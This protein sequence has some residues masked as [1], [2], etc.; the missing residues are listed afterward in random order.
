MHSAAHNAVKECS[1]LYGQYSTACRTFSRASKG[2]RAAGVSGLQKD[3]AC[4]PD[5]RMSVQASLPIHPA[6]GRGFHSKLACAIVGTPLRMKAGCYALARS[7]NR[8][9]YSQSGL[10]PSLF[11]PACPPDIRASV[12]ASLPICPAAGRGFHGKLACAIVGA[13]PR[14]KASCSALTR[15]TAAAGMR[16]PGCRPTCLYRLARP[17]SG[18]L[19]KQAC[20]YAR[21]PGGAFIVIATVTGIRRKVLSYIVKNV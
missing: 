3:P 13:P 7:R 5:I 12:Q 17:I 16:N 20:P 21:L 19:C 18:H 11:I 10:S 2:F 15:S 4:P 14:M 9:R 6:A 1:C 8:R